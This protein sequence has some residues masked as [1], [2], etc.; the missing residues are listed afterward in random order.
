MHRS[1]QITVAEAKELEDKG[2]IPEGSGYRYRYESTGE[3]MV[4]HHINACNT[5]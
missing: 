2:E 3:H 4:E 1:S 5:F